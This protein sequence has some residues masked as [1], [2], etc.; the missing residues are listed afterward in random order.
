MKNLLRLGMWRGILM[1]SASVLASSRGF[2]AQ[3]CTNGVQCSPPSFLV[4][5]FNGMIARNGGKCLDFD[6]PPIVQ[7]GLIRQKRRF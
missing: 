3:V 4:K 7:S 1:L 6:F 5:A 2:A